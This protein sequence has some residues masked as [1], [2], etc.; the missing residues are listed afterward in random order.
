VLFVAADAADPDSGPPGAGADRFE[1]IHT[2]AQF[3]FA[4]MSD[5]LRP[6]IS[7]IRDGINDLGQF[8]LVT[9]L[10]PALSDAVNNRVE[11][12]G[13]DI[14]QLKTCLRQVIDRRVPVNPD[15]L[16]ELLRDMIF[17][18][19][20]LYSSSFSQRMPGWFFFVNIN[21]INELLDPATGAL[22]QL[23]FRADH[24]LP[25]RFKDTDLLLPS[26]PVRFCP[27]S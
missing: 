10:S 14:I 6:L 9:R 5:S 16:G 25:I 8:V 22:F 11:T 3:Q 19:F 4:T 20:G 24:G 2:N 7:K 13:K 17:G 12:I 27:L 26:F 15:E 1:H 18:M 23:V 21:V